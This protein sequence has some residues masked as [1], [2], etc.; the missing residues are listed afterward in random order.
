MAPTQPKV[1]KSAAV[2]STSRGSTSLRSPRLR[3]LASSWLRTWDPILTN[4]TLKTS[5]TKSIL[6]VYVFFLSKT[7]FMYSGKG[8]CANSLLLSDRLCWLS[9]RMVYTIRLSK[10]DQKVDVFVRC[11][12]SVSILL[13]FCFDN[14]NTTSLFSLNI[15]LVDW[16]ITEHIYSFTAVNLRRTKCV[17]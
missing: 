10:G 1:K 17:I 2:P 11:R 3:A 6:Y 13:T 4:S 12:M 15:L 14:W 8:V 9:R 7:N 5:T 16:W